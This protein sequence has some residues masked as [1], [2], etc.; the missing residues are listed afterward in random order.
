MS[1]SFKKKFAIF[2]AFYILVT[3]LHLPLFK[4]YAD[5]ISNSEQVRLN[6]I[7]F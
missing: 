6:T 3:S 7:E 4:V 5:E 1:I 2:F